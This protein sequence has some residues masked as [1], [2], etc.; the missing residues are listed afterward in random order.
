LIREAVAT[1]GNADG[2]AGGVAGAVVP[3]SARHPLAPRYLAFVAATGLSTLGDAAWMIALTATLTSQAGPATTG[4]VLALAGLPRVVAMLG[5]G[6]MTDRR[7]PVTVMVWTDLSRCALMVLAAVLVWV[8]GAPVPLLVAL[9]TVLAFLGS[10]FVPASGALRPQLLPP[11]HLVRGNSLYLIGLRCGQAAGG[12]IGA[13]LLAAGGLAVVAVVNAGSFLASAF[14]V[15]RC[16]PLAEAPT[17]SAPSDAGVPLRRRIA[18]GLRHVRADRDLGILLAVVGL[19]ELAAAGPVNVGLILF[20]NGIGA[21]TPGAGLLLTGFT[22]G[23]TGTFLVN[24]VTPV[25]RLAGPAAIAGMAAQA[26]VLA[27]LGVVGPLWLAL[28]GYAVLGAAGALISLVLVSMIQRR[29]PADVRGRVMSIMSLLVFA[30]V[31]VGNASIGAMIEWLGVTATMAIQGGIAVA[32]LLT[33][34][35]TPGLRA[36][37]LD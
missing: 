16:A 13:W 5:G 36:A 9:A 32:G 4:A 26:A 24:L 37:R 25:G 15:F 22:L 34:A 14:A 21:G 27:G 6:A 10:F 11:K 35:A 29:A 18:D 2:L 7:G 20:A 19:V 17:A 1:A 12:P 30:S 23:A 28:V 8:V 3:A 31:P 33:F